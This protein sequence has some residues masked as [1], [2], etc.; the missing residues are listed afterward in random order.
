MHQKGEGDHDVAREI[1]DDG[2][3]CR[4]TMAAS[5]T[6]WSIDGENCLT[7]SSWAKEKG[8]WSGP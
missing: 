2:I 1:K 3:R 6:V 7:Y 4:R 5:A 8:E